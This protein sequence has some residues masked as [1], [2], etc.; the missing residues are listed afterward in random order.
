MKIADV[1][2]TAVEFVTPDISVEEASRII[3]GKGINGVPVCKGRKVVGFVT[4]KDILSRFYPTMQEFIEDPVHS[5]N[6]EEMEGNIN[7]ILSIPIRKIMSKNPI[8][9]SPDML[10]LKAQSLMFVKKVGRLPVVDEKGNLVGIVSKGDIFR[11]LV[12]QKLP[13]AEEKGFYDWLAKQYDI[14][15]NWQK[16]LKNEIPYLVKLFRKEK[17]KKILDVASST[18]EHSMALAKKGYEVFGIDASSVI[19]KIA[20]QK[21][22]SLPKEISKKLNFLEGHY[23]DL[24]K[25]LPKDFDAAIFM[26]NAIS[27]VFYTEKNI[28][29]NV[30][31]ILNPKRAVLV[32]QITN[33]EKFFSRGGG[34][35]SFRMK[36]SAFISKGKQ[37]F[38]TFFDRD[39]KNKLSYNLAIF[40]KLGEK[41]TFR[42]MN[43][44]PIVYFGRREIASVLKKAGFSKIS[45]Y[46][47]MYYDKVASFDFRPLDSDWLNVV[48]KR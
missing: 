1:M 33:Y 8:V 5:Q 3:F 43:S 28:I 31:K 26:G 30:A 24:M 37:A 15:I 6:F 9:V 11:A 21:K 20:E 34:L 35:R 13:F 4:E 29:N 45:F 44:T 32:F 36:N 22:Q 16:R 40:D 47:S 12:G 2:Q 39:S 48:A 14:I 41:W 27:H 38:L 10:I 17:V 46:G 18:G 7:A 23:K 25:K 19:L 42:R